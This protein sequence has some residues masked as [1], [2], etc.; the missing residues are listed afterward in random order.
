M[1]PA[2]PTIKQFEALLPV[3]CDR[4]T[5][6][7]A[8]HWTPKNP[9]LGHCAVASLVAQNLFGGELLRASLEGIPEF[10][11]MRSHYWNKL[12]DGTE[13][14]FTA[15]QFGGRYPELQSAIAPRTRALSSPDTVK[16]YKLLAWRFAS[17]VSKYRLFA[18]SDHYQTC[19]LEALDSPCQKM[20]FG[21]VVTHMDEVVYKGCNRTIPGLKSLCEPKCIRFGIASRTESML[22]ACGHAEEMAL[23]AVACRSKIPLEACDLY[24][25]GFYPNG[26]PWIKERAEHTCLRCSVQMHYAGV[27]RI[28]VPTTYGWDCLSAG[29][30]LETAKAYATGEKKV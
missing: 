21:C 11:Y 4:E 6:S 16:R 22:G 12:P 28:W 27:R 30:A 29:E 15:P 14:D 13:V 23:W 24:I 19:F 7:D 5:T 20:R 3:I 18:T 2:T 25:A 1:K 17:A 8:E 10:A 9:L 26:L